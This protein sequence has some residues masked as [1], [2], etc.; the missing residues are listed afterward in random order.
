M[1]FAQRKWKKRNLGS[2]LQKALGEH[3]TQYRTEP[4]GPLRCMWQQE[5]PLPPPLSHFP[6]LCLEIFEHDYPLSNL[7]GRLSYYFSDD[8]FRCSLGILAHLSF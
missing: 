1:L 8:F 2:L 3:L 6:G 7:Q 4:K 5:S